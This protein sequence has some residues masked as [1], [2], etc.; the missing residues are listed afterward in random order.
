[1]FIAGAFSSKTLT[2]V[3]GSPLLNANQ[4][5]TDTID[6]VFLLKFCRN[7]VTG[8]APEQAMAATLFPNPNQGQFTLRWAAADSPKHLVICDMLGKVV[9]EAVLKAGTT[10]QQFDGSAW[11]SGLYTWRIDAGQSRLAQ[12]KFSL[13]GAVK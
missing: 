7:T 6:D 12:G 9:L 4:V 2:L 5:P 3:S 11:P 10:E 8:I 1:L 13:L